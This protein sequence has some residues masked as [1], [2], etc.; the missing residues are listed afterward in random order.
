MHHC[1]RW[2]TPFPRA[3]LALIFIAIGT[4]LP[5]RVR[6]GFRKSPRTFHEAS[7]MTRKLQLWRH[8]CPGISPTPARFPCPSDLCRPPNSSLLLTL[9]AFRRSNATMLLFSCSLNNWQAEERDKSH[10]HQLRIDSAVF[11]IFRANS[12]LDFSNRSPSVPH[13]FDA[14]CYVVRANRG[15]FLQDCP[16]QKSKVLANDVNERTSE[17]GGNPHGE[18]VGSSK[19]L[20][21]LLHVIFELSKRPHDF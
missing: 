11:W 15:I 6:D 21:Q 12:N 4:Q 5:N 1:F 7:G 3:T 16:L 17:F 8:F 9:G 13:C 20:P 18:G 2:A 14:S 10:H 19:R